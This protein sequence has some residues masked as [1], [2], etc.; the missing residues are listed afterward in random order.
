[1]AIGTVAGREVGATRGRKMI[2]LHYA[3]R[4]KRLEIAIMLEEL[5]LWPFLRGETLL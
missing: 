2:D 4:P 3:P 1:M 5:E